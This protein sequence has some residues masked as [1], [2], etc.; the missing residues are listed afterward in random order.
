MAAA[1]AAV[2]IAVAG[3][4]AG[5]HLLVAGGPA[6]K[7]GNVSEVVSATNPRTDVSAVVSY[8][9]RSW[10]TRME[11]WVTGIPAGTACQFWVV[12]SQ[13]RRWPAGSWT[14]P[15]GGQAADYPASASLQADHLRSF[16]IISDRHV[17]VTVPAS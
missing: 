7:V 2:L 12:D 3:G 5:A 6:A 13:G 16:E 9:G 8:S 10:G 17:L 15:P 14:V 4:A 11:V 1:A